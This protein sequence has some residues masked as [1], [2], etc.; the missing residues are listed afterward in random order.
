VG[1]GVVGHIIGGAAVSPV[2]ALPAFIP[3]VIL[4]RLFARGERSASAIAF[5]LI[6]GQ[7]W[8]HTLASFTGHHASTRVSSMLAGHVA[9]TA[10]AVLVLRRR[11]AIAWAKARRAALVSYLHSLIS[12]LRPVPPS[13]PSRLLV[14]ATEHFCTALSEIIGIAVVRRGPPS[15]GLS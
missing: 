9:A 11:Q 10:V 12:L 6:S 15:V 7:L 5:L 1:L 8:V 13:A 14:P 4:A 3:L 2:I